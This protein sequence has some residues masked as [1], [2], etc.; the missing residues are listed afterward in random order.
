MKNLSQN[1]QERTDKYFLRSKQILLEK[2]INSYVRYQVFA[3]QNISKLVGVHEAV[4]FIKDTVNDRVIVYALKD[5][6]SYQ[7]TEPILKIEGRVQDLIDLE[8]VYLEILSGNLTG[9]INLSEVRENART[10]IEAAQSKPVYYFGARH[11]HY[12]LDEKI[13]QICQ[14]AGFAGCST[15]FGAKA[16]KAQGIGTIPHALI[17]SYAAY[18]RENNFTG[19]PTVEAA[20]AFDEVINQ[21]VPRIVLIDTFNREIDDSIETARALKNLHGLRIDTCGE[22]Y[23]QDA[24]TIELPI[25]TIPEKYLHSRGVSIAAV[26]ALR[27]GLDQAGFSNL[28]ITVSSGFNTEKIVAF[29]QADRI[30]QQLHGRPLFDSIGTGSVGR[31][32]MTT[33]DIVAYYSEKEQSWLSFS[34]V[35]REEVPS[36]RLN[37]Y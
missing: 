14:E 17:V 26:W 13:A 11:F 37:K 30:Y 24:R 10:I 21:K 33:S 25:L 28:E 27:R 12:D 16:W 35:G 32:L 20:K 2:G 9:P 7:A 5:G 18:L 23:A 36:S 1:Y 6:D 31:P 4:E 8:T 3:R 19:N 15:D 22:N 29:S 34:K